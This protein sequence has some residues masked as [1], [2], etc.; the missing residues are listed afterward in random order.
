MLHFR[1]ELTLSYNSNCTIIL[2]FK[3][4]IRS[5]FIMDSN[6]TTLSSTVLRSNSSAFVKAAEASPYVSDIE[7]K[8][9]LPITRYYGSKLRL[10]SWI[11]SIFEDFQYKTVL[12]AFGGTATVS[13]LFRAHNKD[14]TYNDILYSNY[15]S[16]RALLSNNSLRYRRNEIPLFLK[17]VTPNQGFI[18]KT[19]NGYFFTDDENKW[20]DGVT[21][22]IHRKRDIQYKSDLF[23]CLFQACLQKRPFNLFHRKNLYIRVNNDRSTKFGNW[24]TW[25]RSFEEL[26]LRA[27]EQLEKAKSISSGTANVLM[28]SDATSLSSG[29]D[30]VYIDPPYVKS[31]K[32][33]LYYD[34]R[35]HFLEGLSNYAQWEQ[36][37]DY[38]SNILGLKCNESITDWNHIKTS[39]ERLFDFIDSHSN[40]IVALS[41]AEGGYPSI[42][43]ISK[44][45]NQKFKSVAV[46]Q[47]TL[48]HALR[49]N[50]SNEVIF[51]GVN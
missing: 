40:S 14:V 7:L 39:K 48:S 12:D 20:L 19:F 37:I 50:R 30:F 1:V 18:T 5:N 4:R 25:E 41:Y 32:N 9:I 46:F 22:S 49:K 31:N 51:L 36:L 47:N 43:E 44:Y 29:Y 16:A 17:K 15:Y 10:I 34:N 2:F 13:L 11:S 35:Y 27:S 6:V 21:K 45:F 3:S 28:P 8:K 38:Q 23:Y 26:F 24:R 42:N 33:D